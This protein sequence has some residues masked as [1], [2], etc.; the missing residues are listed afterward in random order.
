[1]PELPGVYRFYGLN[2]H[3]LYVGKGKEP[4]GASLPFSADYR[5]ATD[6]RLSAEIRRIG[7]EATAGGIGALL[8]ESTLVRALLPALTTRFAPQN[9][10]VVRRASGRT[11]PPRYL[12]AAGIEPR[13]LPGRYGWFSVP[14][15]RA[16]R[17]ATSPRSFA[18]ALDRAQAREAQQAL[19]PPAGCGAAP[20][21]ASAPR[22]RPRTTPGSS[23]P[24][25]RSASPLALRGA[26]A[27]R[28][29]RHPVGTHRPA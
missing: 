5:S 8:R 10:A 13:E 2:A 27:I 26:V 6:L 12:A 3:P 11:R 24:S 4:Q 14:A 17:C 19:L 25:R 28:E 18:L 7:F 20:A 29:A 1:M 16:G 9:D 22:R 21:P 15:R 23:R